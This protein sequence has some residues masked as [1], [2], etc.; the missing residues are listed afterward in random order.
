MKKNIL[1]IVFILL[2][3]LLVL[4]WEGPKGNPP[5]ENAAMPLHA[6]ALAQT[7]AG[8]LHIMGKV[9]IGTETDN[10]NTLLFVKT[11]TGINAEIDLKSGDKGHWGIYLDEGTEDLRFWNTENRLI[12][13]KDGNLQ[14]T[15]DV[16]GTRLCIGADCRDAWPA[17]GG[18]AVMPTGISG[19]TL[20]HD[21]TNWVANS[22]LFNNGTN[23]G[24]GTVVP[25]ERLEVSGNLLVRG[26]I[27]S[28]DSNRP[29]FF[30][31]VT[32]HDAGCP[33]VG[34]NPALAPLACPSGSEKIG[35][36]HT[37]PGACDGNVEG[38][39]INGETDSGWIALCMGN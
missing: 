31:Y 27:I 6:G 30:F 11:A 7:K 1:I 35:E 33:P 17:G 4:A 24:I 15:G 28:E 34:W 32:D 39:G 5:T 12:L 36:F 3:P 16:K 26:K 21:G 13:T 29:M 8:S 20:R 37:G 22:V 38:I 19:Q 10:G 25:A 14:V 18:G 23:V 9:G 2:A